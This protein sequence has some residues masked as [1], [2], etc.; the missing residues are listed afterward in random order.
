MNQG[1]VPMHEL[2]RTELRN[3]RAERSWK[4]ETCFWCDSKK[5][6]MALLTKG[7]DGSKE[8]AQRR[9]R[10]MESTVSAPVG[11]LRATVHASREQALA[12]FCFARVILTVVASGRARALCIRASRTKVCI[13]FELHWLQRSVGGKH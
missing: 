6:T 8:D 5:M 11:K 9:R 12:K 10:E 3:I 1:P 2:L 7:V 13:C 4:K